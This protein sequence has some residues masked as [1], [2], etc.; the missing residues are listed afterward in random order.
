MQEI[1]IIDHFDDMAQIWKY[2]VQIKQKSRQ[3]LNE[4]N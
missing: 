1:K 2:L 3:S 4:I